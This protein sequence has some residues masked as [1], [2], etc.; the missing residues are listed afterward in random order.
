M[1]LAYF[2]YLVKLSS[3][4]YIC[5]VGKKFEYFQLIETFFLNSISFYNISYI[6]M[7]I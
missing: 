3:W 7:Y 5:Q 4:E 1:I 6:N 2:I